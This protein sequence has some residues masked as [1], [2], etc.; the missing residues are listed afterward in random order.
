MLFQF[1]TFFYKIHESL[2]AAKVVYLPKKWSLGAAKMVYLHK[3]W[4][5]SAAKLV[6]LPKKWALEGAKQ[7]SE[8]PDRKNYND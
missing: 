4:S 5:Y 1:S 7:V 8:H 6:Y 3:K 2:R